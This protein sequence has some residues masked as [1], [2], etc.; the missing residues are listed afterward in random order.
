[1]AVNG[2]VQLLLYLLIGGVI[3][4]VVFWILGMLSLPQPVKQI[5]LVIVA[6]VVLLW[7]L[8]TFGIFTL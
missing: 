4:Y 5:I 8:S 1:M 2:L 6:I 7:L 3:V